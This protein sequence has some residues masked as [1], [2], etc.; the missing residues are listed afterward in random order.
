MTS[1]SVAACT[2]ATLLFTMSA[3]DTPPLKIVYRVAD[4]PG[5]D[6]GTAD[7]AEVDMACA[8]V[9]HLRILSP[10]DPNVPHISICVDVAP[11]ANRDLCAIGRI[12]LEQQELPR[13][14]LEVQVTVWPRDAVL[15]PETGLLDCSRIPV[16]F[17]ATMGFP[18]NTSPGPAFGGRAFYY[19]GDTETVVTLGCTDRQSINACS[20]NDVEVTTTVLDFENL[21]LLV[22]EQV[23]DEL[24]LAIG[25]PEL[26]NEDYVLN[27][28]DS[29]VLERT[30]IRPVPAWGGGV[31]LEFVRSAC[32]Q[33]TEDGAQTTTTLRCKDTTPESPTFDH[34]GLRLPKPTL[35]Q[36]LAAMALAAFPEEGL[37]IGI[38]VDEAG[39][40][41][42]GQSVTP[43][44]GTVQYLNAARTGLVANMTSTNGIFVSRDA[45]YGTIFSAF[46]GVE[47]AAAK[48]GRVK[49]K[50]TIALLQFGQVVE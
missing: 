48:A 9:L 20:A 8:S 46:M 31:D 23:G 19:P 39:N 21:P 16:E 49:G 12:D 11:N 5:Q 18:V 15:D 50:V 6:C 29:A 33:V 4:G 36:I 17:D 22:S 30:V 26:V 28:A 47:N 34:A 32:I 41:V 10:S 27:S 7:C 14:I 3:C 42:G 37:T 24:S 44:A 2:L 40:P 1:P 25:E 43:T 38:V 45:P 13:E 35:D